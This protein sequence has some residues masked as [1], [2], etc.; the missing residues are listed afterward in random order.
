M[1]RDQILGDIVEEVG[2]LEVKFRSPTA[3][4]AETEATL[5]DDV[6]ALRS[7]MRNVGQS[8]GGMSCNIQLY[9]V[10]V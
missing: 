4:T 8:S 6:Q 5:V 2:E 1:E 9:Q 7:I 3:K 10:I